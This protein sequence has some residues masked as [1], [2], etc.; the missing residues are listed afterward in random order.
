MDDSV[1]LIERNW[2]E[3]QENSSISWGITFKDDPVVIGMIGSY[4]LQLQHFRGEVGY[5]LHADHWRKGIMSEALQ[6]VVGTGF[7]RLGFHSIE[8]VTDPLNVASNALLR[9]NGFMREGLFKE[10]YFWNGKFLDS[11]VY[12]KLAP[13]DRPCSVGQEPKFPGINAVTS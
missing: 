2:K 11:A 10:N 9:S 7:Q 13:Q 5:T 1:E 12:S 3:Q 8:A 6:A 4:R